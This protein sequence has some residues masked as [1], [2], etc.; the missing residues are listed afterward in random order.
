[1]L[2]ASEARLKNPATISDPTVRLFCSSIPSIEDVP[3]WRD[4]RN[5]SLRRFGLRK[6]DTHLPLL[7]EANVPSDVNCFAV[8][9]LPLQA[10]N[11]T[12]P[13]TCVSCGSCVSWRG[14][15]T[16]RGPYHRSRSIPSPADKIQ[17]LC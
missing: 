11:L 8:V 17:N 15:R 12:A 1:M 7:S 16:F 6:L 3:Q 9:V 13:Q 4:D 14:N 10:D 5:R 2:L